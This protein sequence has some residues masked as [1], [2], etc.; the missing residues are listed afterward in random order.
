MSSEDPTFSDP[1]RVAINRVYTGTGDRGETRLVGGQKVPKHALRIESYGTVDELN[2]FVG[3]A[4]QT[5]VELQHPALGAFAEDLRRVQHQ[6][7]NLGS[8]L[9][10]LP[11]DLHPQ[12]PRILKSDVTWLEASM[13]AANA[14]LPPLRSFVLPGGSRL[15]TDLHVCRTLCR[16]AERVMSALVQ[17]SS[18][19]EASLVY[20]NRL[21]DAFFVWSRWVQHQ[22]GAPEELWSPRV[23][24]GQASE[25]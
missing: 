21:S 14:A 8:L 7:F 3:A 18:V 16:R 12:Q 6:L 13:D 17:E 15:N 22:L 23:G 5:V 25:G 2:A 9:A 11:E 19:D 10:T 1:Q 4:R 20:V 24:A